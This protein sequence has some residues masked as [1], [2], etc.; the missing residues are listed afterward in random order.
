MNKSIS[1]L[2]VD[3]ER[4]SRIVL[5]SL[6]TEFVPEIHIVGEAA[7]IEE[8]YKLINDMNPELVFLDIQ[9]PG[10]NGFGLLKKWDELPFDVI[11]VTSFDQYAINA[12]KF[13]ALDYLLKPVE[14]DILRASV[15]KAM[16]NIEKKS[17]SNPQIVALLDN[18]DPGVQDKKIAIHLNDKVR[19]IDLKRIVYIE[20]DDSYC[21]ITM[22]NNERF[23]TSRVLKD[24]EDI[25]SGNLDF[26]RIHKSCMIN[27]AHIK[28]YSKG[29][30]C[31]IE[32]YDGKQ[33]EVARRKKQE[34]LERLKSK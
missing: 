24:F 25:L 21:E 10:G 13:S 31:V 9:M 26:I 3:D 1:A 15:E 23:T 32:M 22:A 4:N 18:I 6:I 16:H 19:L 27:A 33:F 20:A 11:F 8:A 34:V 14:I 29:E 30:P 2:I 17:N 12:I 5:R 28:E 7:N